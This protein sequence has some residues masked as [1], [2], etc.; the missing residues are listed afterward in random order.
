VANNDARVRK[1]FASQMISCIL[2]DYL[3]DENYQSNECK[4]VNQ[5]SNQLPYPFQIGMRL[6][7]ALGKYISY[8]TVSE[9][10]VQRAMLR[11]LLY[12]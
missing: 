2:D 12:G 7:H 6:F 4:L 10:N 11:D 9:N 3:E 8:E 1:N 5:K